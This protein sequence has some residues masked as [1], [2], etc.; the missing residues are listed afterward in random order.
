[1]NASQFLN[2]L[3]CRVSRVRRVM[4]LA[5]FA[6]LT[7][8]LLC[9]SANAAE[10]MLNG[11]IGVNL[12][13]ADFP[14]RAGVYGKTYM[15]PNREEMAYY[16]SKGIR[17]FRIPFLWERMQPDLNGPLSQA[18]LGHLD[19]VVTAANAEHVHLILDVHNYDRYQGKLVGDD[20]RLE[21]AL[22]G[23]WSQLA[24]HYRNAKSIYGYGIMNEP[25]DTRGTWP[26]TAQ[27]VIDAIRTEDRRHFILLAGEHWSGAQ[28]WPE[29]NPKLLE[30]KDPENRIIYEAHTYWDR[31]G[32]GVYKHSYD[33]DH[34][35][36]NI[37]VD[38]VRP[39][40]EWLKAHHAHG[41]IGE[42]GVPNNDPR[43]NVVLDHFLQYIQENGISG[44]YWAGGPIWHHY[45]LSCEPAAGV[46]APQMKVLSA[47]AHSHNAWGW[48][49]HSK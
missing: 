43:W 12:A 11:K 46:D 37:G 28:V 33:E 3:N 47:H 10:A 34:V 9:T 39:F 35:Y 31:D 41:L 6:A 38:R 49:G 30:V 2:A 14:P 20:P 18:E 7:G 15:Y 24:E 21:R 4:Y 48:L 25:F 22:A 40:V 42:F 29:S 19:A 32:S 16:K 44:T 26:H 1:M 23:L 8:A 45:I 17:L 27:K 13:G 5:A 36:P